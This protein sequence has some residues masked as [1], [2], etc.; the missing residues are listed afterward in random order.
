MTE[1]TNGTLFAVLDTVADT[2]IGGVQ[3]HK[4]EASAIRSFGD[5]ASMPNSIVA[6]HPADF[7][8]LRLGH[9]TAD[10]QLVPDYA[11]ILTGAQWLATQ[12]RSDS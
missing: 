6:L 8:L 4:H 2:I 12:Q 7:S 5:I 10:N 3:L 9:L 11:V 1:P